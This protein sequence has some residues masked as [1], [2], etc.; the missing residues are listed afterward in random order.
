MERLPILPSSLPGLSLLLGVAFLSNLPLGYLREGTRRYSFAW[1]VCIHA[2][3]PF[4]ILLRR[5]LDFG[6]SIVPFSLGCALLGQFVGGRVAQR[7]K[8]SGCN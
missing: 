7:R 8:K 5:W 6:W 3:I 1:F 4:L 2:S